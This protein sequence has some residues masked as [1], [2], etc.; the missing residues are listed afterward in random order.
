MFVV[1][2]TDKPDSQHIRLDNRPRHLEY[3]K[4]NLDKVVMAGPVLSDDR[5]AMVGSILVLDFAERAQLDAFLAGDPYA[6]AGLFAGV[7]VLPFRK[8]LP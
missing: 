4:T 3:I 8:V 7:T 2:C 5:Q 1:H 6:Q